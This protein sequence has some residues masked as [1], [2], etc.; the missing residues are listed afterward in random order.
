MAGFARRS[1]AQWHYARLIAA[2]LLQA[3]LSLSSCALP[4]LAST[5][6]V[7]SAAT[8][9]SPLAQLTVYSVEGGFL[10]ARRLSDGMLRWQYPKPELFS[11]P[12]RGPFML[13]PLAVDG[14]IYGGDLL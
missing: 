5:S 10:S 2:L 8:P 3:C 7:R 4:G 11:P 6:A 14:A 1:P 13:A 12:A 9:D